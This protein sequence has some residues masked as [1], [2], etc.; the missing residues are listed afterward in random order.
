MMSELKEL[1]FDWFVVLPLAA[2]FMYLVIFVVCIRLRHNDKK[3]ERS[4]P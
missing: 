3:Y 4:D 2:A 1:A